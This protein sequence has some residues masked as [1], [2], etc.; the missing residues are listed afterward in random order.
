MTGLDSANKLSIVD[1]G[2]WE[3]DDGGGRDQEHKEE[4]CSDGVDHFSQETNYT[5]RVRDGEE[6]NL[7]VFFTGF[8]FEDS[9]GCETFD[10]F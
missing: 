4:D 1:L 7:F 10:T 6:E 9:T 3:A 8:A 5:I 2:Q